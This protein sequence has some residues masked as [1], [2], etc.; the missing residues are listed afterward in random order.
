MD[1]RALQ[2]ALRSRGF[3]SVMANARIAHDIILNAIKEAGFMDKVTIKG[4]VV[5]SGVSNDVRRATMDMDLDFLH[6]SLGDSAIQR[7]VSKLNRFAGCRVE[8]VGEI[9]ELRQQEYRGKRFYLALTDENG[10]VVK[11]KLDVGVHTREDVRQHIFGFEV[12]SRKSQVR[13]FVNSREQIFVEKLKS[14]LLLGPISNRYRDVYDMYYLSGDIRKRVLKQYI[15]QYIFDDAKMFENDFD[16][17]IVRLKKV[18][19]N[20]LYVKR[21]AQPKNAWL[22]VPA[23]EVINGLLEF[24]RSLP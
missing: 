1:F 6:Y 17:I 24:I 11:T 5:M 8:L 13:L 16:A 9:Q 20:K 21:L 2:L 15:Q 18:F 3:S 22:D 19:S 10:L 23:T 12:V 7:F 14:L 4:G